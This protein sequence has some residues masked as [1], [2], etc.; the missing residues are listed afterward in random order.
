[1][2]LVHLK[3]TAYKEELDLDAINLLTCPCERSLVKNPVH[4]VEIGA[5]IRI[6]AK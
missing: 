6:Q 5:L 3:F 4:R 2:V 1:M